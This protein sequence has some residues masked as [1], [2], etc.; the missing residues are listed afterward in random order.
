[1][2]NI[3][4]VKHSEVLYKLQQSGIKYPTFK[5]TGMHMRDINAG[6]KNAPVI[7]LLYGYVQ[8]QGR[9]PA[10][11]L[12]ARW[13][14]DNHADETEKRTERKEVIQRTIKLVLDFYRELHT[15]GLLASNDFFGVVRYAKVDDIDLGVDYTAEVSEAQQLITLD[16]IGVQAAIGDAR[17]YTREGYFQP[18][19]AARKLTRTG[20]ALKWDGP[21]H[22]LTNEFRRAA[23]EPVSGTLLFTEAHVADLVEEVAGQG[24]VRTAVQADA[25][26]PE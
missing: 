7:P 6:Y 12:C 26:T 8:T 18:V 10:P 5:R 1:M 2:T 19:K 9:L 23:Y 17:A 3:W 22:W 16:K 4:F 20:G 15:F 14:Y 24:I 21:I 25:D 13:L 11:E